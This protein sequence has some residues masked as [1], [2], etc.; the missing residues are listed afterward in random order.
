MPVVV[1]RHGGRRPGHKEN[2][3]QKTIEMN[4]TRLGSPNGIEVN[5][6]L[7]GETY[8]TVPDVL[9]DIFIENG[10]ATETDAATAQIEAP[11][12]D[13]TPYAAL[14]DEELAA[15]VRE[16]DPSAD[17]DAIADDRAA[18]EEALPPAPSTAD[19]EPAAKPLSKMNLAELQEAAK[20]VGVASDGLTRKQIIAAITKASK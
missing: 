1:Q 9:A 11:V 15:K 16:H 8:Y 6:Y 2:P 7:E 4:E 18:V 3:M 17:P 5:E 13:A 20:K 10:W 12:S 19:P 14:S